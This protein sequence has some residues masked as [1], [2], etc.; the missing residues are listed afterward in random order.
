ML[1]VKVPAGRAA[2]DADVRDV[3]VGE[4]VEPC[5][6]PEGAAV[7]LPRPPLA[8]GLPSE[9]ARPSVPDLQETVGRPVAAVLTPLAEPVL[10]GTGCSV[11]HRRAGIA[12]AARPLAAL[13][14]VRPRCVLRGA[15]QDIPP[16]VP[17]AVDVAV[18]N[19]AVRRGEATR[20]PVASLLGL[21]I[22]PRD[23]PAVVE[24]VVAARHPA[25]P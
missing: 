25:Y 23:S 5:P 1:E 3:V 21:D 9:A 16:E 19:V 17:P 15:D 2:A 11:R 24:A 13:A 8:T 18:A 7:V 10:L 14:V 12:D 22:Q 4:T 6:A 20:R